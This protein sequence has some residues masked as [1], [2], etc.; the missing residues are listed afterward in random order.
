MTWAQRKS[1]KEKWNEFIIWL[2]GE[3]DYKNLKMKKVR[4]IYGFEFE[5]NRLCDW[6]NRCIAIK[7][8]NDG[9]VNAGMLIEDHYKVVTN[10]EF[11]FLG[12]NKYDP[13]IVIEIIEL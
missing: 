2:V 13:K 5:S 8:I 9:L 11:K 4:M 6:D 10:L 12:I 7:Y 1:S 3:I